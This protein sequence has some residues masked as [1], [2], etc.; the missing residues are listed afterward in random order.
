MTTGEKAGVGGARA[1]GAA[2]TFVELQI[3]GMTCASCANRV[4][5]KLNKLENVTAE[6]N[7]ATEK[8]RVEFG[9][10]IETQL[11][12]DTVSKAGYSAT[13]PR[14]R[15][16][17]PTGDNADAENAGNAGNAT[18]DS[19]GV[20]RVESLR[21]R[22][23]ISA[24]LSIPVIAVAMVPA[25]QFTYWQWLSLTLAA[26]VVVWGAWPFHRAAAINLRH[27]TFTMD[28]LVS[29][30][31][32]AA[33][34]WS[35]YA[36]FFGHAGMPGMT[37]G[38]EFSLSPS[39]GAGDIY[40]EA[41][42]GV[43]TFVLL[44][45][46]FEAR[47]KRS[48]GAAL[49]SLLELGAK[50]VAVL[51]TGSDGRGVET[52]IPVEDLKVGDEFVVRPGEK[53]A[54]DGLIIDGAS[55]IDTSMVTGESVPAEVSEGDA[56]V[57][58]TVNATGR[59]IVSATRVGADTQLAQMAQMVEDAQ[60]GKA[61]AQRL[62]DRISGVF[63][64]IVL[65][66]AAATFAYWLVTDAGA[67]MAF[68]A[69]VAVLI[70]ACPCALGLAT[71][72]ALMVGTGRGAQLGILIKGPEVL[73]STRKVDTIVLD[74][75]GTV[76]TGKHA[77]VST[78]VAEGE[79]VTQ[80]LRMAG[81]VEDASEHPIARAIAVGAREQVG[82]LPAVAGF[83]NHEGLGVSG[84]VVAGGGPEGDGVGGGVAGEVD[85]DE[86]VV[87]GRP[88]LLAE[89]SMPLTDELQRA[90]DAAS[91]RGQTAV[92]VGW[93]GRA[94]GVLVVADQIKETSAEAIRRFRDLGL[95]PI[96]LTGDNAAVAASVAAEV[97]IDP[98]PDTVI[99]EVMPADKV[100]Q[101]RRL[102]AEGRVV[103]MVGDG[104]NDAAALATADLGLAIGTG[105]DAAIEASDLTLVRGDLRSAADAIRLSRSTLGTIRGNLFWAFA[106]NVAA[107]PLAAAGLLNPMIAGAA[108]AFSS[109]F[110]V[111]NSLRLRRFRAA[112]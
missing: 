39:D 62:A 49:R 24:L 18:D 100:E 74:K 78:S 14:P 61:A 99:A 93:G 45:R 55:A 107:L 43:T 1:D 104:V 85:D 52:R 89:Q 44:G 38:F 97:G 5:R 53:I 106:Y 21:Q 108:M 17:T 12:L 94:R 7:Y 25:W 30:G 91:D 88:A 29:I 82:D 111:A 77:L 31:T 86:V 33:F 58:G 36:L 40:L 23:I 27:G 112:V 50:D 22:V 76:T 54:S 105:T 9:P 28:T 95:T 71:P 57:G 48:A 69:A 26:P 92:A 19:A 6:V 35:L 70:I 83:R 63:V 80:V 47:S 60:S 109:V 87:V 65:V 42:A 56:V 51:R 34:L 75:T 2:P 67:S 96:L 102:Q 79:D 103:A 46:Y 3:E 64:P 41:A 98:G 72:M 4:E 73:E 10:G 81:A 84:R 16:P 11:L 20:D 101:V 37:H 68:T 110:V 15:K 59:L 32:S 13:V 66:L 8:A 90:M